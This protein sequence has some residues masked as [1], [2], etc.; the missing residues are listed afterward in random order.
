[1]RKHFHLSGSLAPGIF[2]LILFSSYT[3]SYAL[4]PS[5]AYTLKGWKLQI[6]GPIDIDNLVNYSSGYFFLNNDGLLEFSLDASEKGF[7]PH[8]KFVRSELRYNDNWKLPCNKELSAELEADS[9]LIPDKVTVMQIHGITA[10]GSDA[11]PLLRIAVNNGSLYAFL[12]NAGGK[13]DEIHLLDNAGK[14]FF[15]VDILVNGYNLSVSVNGKTVFE[16]DI[17]YWNYFN[18]FKIGCYPQANEGKVDVIVKSFSV[19]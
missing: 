9:L 8:A 2:C 15:S 18:Y 1:M 5:S 14:T 10:S 16:R 17:S 6:P 19:R 4:A 11:P 7:T 13:A 12:M 3:A